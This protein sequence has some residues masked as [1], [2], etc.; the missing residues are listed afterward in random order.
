MTHYHT[1]IN[2]N[3]QHD[4]LRYKVVDFSVYG[5]LLKLKYLIVPRL[6]LLEE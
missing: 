3:S 6:P 1:Y 4:E 2:H 5:A